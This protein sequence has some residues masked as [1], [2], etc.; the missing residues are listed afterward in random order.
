MTGGSR[1]MLVIGEA[2]VDVLA[3]PT[4]A[5]S[6]RPGGSA[7]NVALGLS[8]LGHAVRLATRIGDDAPGRQIREHLEHSGVELAK[9]SV[10]GA[11]TSRA[12]ARLAADGSATYEFDLT[13]NPD[14]AVVDGAYGSTPVHVHTGSLATALGPGNSLVV[15]AAKRLRAVATLSYDPNLRPALL[16]EPERERPGVERM[17]ALSDVVKASSEDLAWLHPGVDPH[18]IA[19]RWAL[20]GPSL[21]VLTLGGE[22]ATAFWRHGSYRLP[23]SPVDVVDTVGAGDAFM[24]GL[25]SGLLHTGLLGVG[26]ADTTAAARSRRALRGATA[27]ARLPEA[28]GPA[29]TFAA[30]VA[31][32]TC[33]RHGADPPTRRDLG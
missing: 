9:G 19:E 4:G 31:A 22:G 29:L 33:S 23:P 13:W 10:T 3:P 7:A 1:P 15:T 30:R 16:S 27:S 12:V 18:L 20:T 5:R 26:P 21:V 28:L 2:L 17:V 32:L 6:S 24:A 8:R 14:P 25:L 11:P